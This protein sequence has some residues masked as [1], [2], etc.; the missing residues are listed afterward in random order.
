MTQY[1]ISRML[2]SE[3]YKLM[4]NKVTFAGFGGHDRS[5]CSPCFAPDDEASFRGFPKTIVDNY[6]FIYIHSVNF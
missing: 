1:F 5:N 6:S 3:L 4:V 2:F